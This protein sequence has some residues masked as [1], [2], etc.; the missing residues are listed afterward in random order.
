MPIFLQRQNKHPRVW[1]YFKVV[2]R[3][4]A[5]PPAASQAVAAPHGLK[6]ARE[7]RA[8]HSI[9]DGHRLEP[10]QRTGAHVV[11]LLAAAGGHLNA[12]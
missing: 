6:L 4:S 8:V 7:V 12:G 10:L 2:R 9:D 1:R 3:D 11:I 5:G